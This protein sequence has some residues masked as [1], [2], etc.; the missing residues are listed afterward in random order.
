MFLKIVFS[1]SYCIWIRFKQLLDSKCG[2][3]ACQGA[4]AIPLVNI[5]WGTGV[6]DDGRGNPVQ[7]NFNGVCPNFENGSC[8][9]PI[10]D[11]GGVGSPGGN[12]V[13]DC[14]LCLIDESV[15]QAID[16]LHANLNSSLFGASSDPGKNVNKCQLTMVKAATKFARAK[17]KI[18]GKCWTNVDKGKD[19]FSSSDAAGCIDL[20]LKEGRHQYRIPKEELQD[21]LRKPTEA[22]P[23]G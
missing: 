3:P 11:C 13:S 10:D 4:M 20:S 12:G 17:S 14:L 6:G 15:D 19:D 5:G 16:L 18:L 2:R 1:V 7:N 9:F 8:G 21:L 22:P 23:G